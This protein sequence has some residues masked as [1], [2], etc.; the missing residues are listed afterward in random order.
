MRN[1]I[2][3]LTGTMIGLALTASQSL[4]QSIYEPYTFTTLAGEAGSAGFADGVGS[5]ARFNA[6]SGVVVDNVGNVY[7]AEIYDNT[8]RKVTPAGV[9]TTQAGLSRWST[10]LRSAQWS[11]S[12][13]PEWRTVCGRPGFDR[14]GELTAT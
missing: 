7:V 14:F 6:L 3:L 11:S 5:A 2:Y 12:M 13:L 1:R 10:A 9:V 4:A 8:I